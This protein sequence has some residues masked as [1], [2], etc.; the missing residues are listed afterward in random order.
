MLR[1]TSRRRQRGKSIWDVSSPP[2]S[3][4][5]AIGYWASSGGTLRS[6]VS[7]TIP[8]E[9]GVSV[10]SCRYEVSGRGCESG[11]VHRSL[12]PVSGANSSVAEPRPC[13][14]GARWFRLDTEYGVRRS[15]DSG[16]A[17]A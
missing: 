5:A 7:D 6:L 9:V 10:S 12:R 3:H 2:G 1:E 8:R 4:T 17:R 16:G 14:Y 13:R 15:A 11:A